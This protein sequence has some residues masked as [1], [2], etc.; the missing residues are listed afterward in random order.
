M[1]WDRLRIFHAVADAGSVTNASEVLNRSQTAI[2][3]QI[4]NLETDLGIGLF[5]RHARGLILTEQGEMLFDA[6][7]FMRK[8]LEVATAH[9]R[10][11]KEKV[12]GDLKVT[13]TTC[14]GALW[15]AP[16]LSQFYET[17]PDVSLDLILDEKVFDLPMRE[18]DVAIRMKEPSQTDLVRLKLMSIRMQI[19]ATTTYLEKHAP[20]VDLQQLSQHRL[21]CQKNGVN[22]VSAGFNFVRNII[23]YKPMS[24]LTVN[25][26]FGALQAVLQNAGIGVLPDYLT[27]DFPQLQCVLPALQSNEIPVYLAYPEELRPSRRVQAFRDFIVDQVHDYKRKKRNREQV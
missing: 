11:S 7:S 6:A 23:C 24:F 3:R 27:E 25:N 21:V 12:F 16:R 15:L 14:F 13:T 5:H 1:D 8:R 22:Q 10:D 18:A 2:S 20:L 4:R 17:Y 9:I 19:Y 26:Y